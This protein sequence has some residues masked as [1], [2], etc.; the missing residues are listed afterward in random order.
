MNKLIISFLFS[1]C[2]ISAYD[3]SRTS[4]EMDTRGEPVIGQTIQSPTKNYTLTKELGAGAFG[5]VFE[6]ATDLGECF[7]LKWYGAASMSGWFGDHLADHNREFILGQVLD[8]PNIIKS[9]ESFTDEDE[10]PFNYTVLELV[11]G[12][13]LASINRGDLELTDAIAAAKQ[14]ISGIHH[15]FI[16]EYLHLDLHGS[17]IMLSQNHEVKIIDLSSFFSFQEIR[18]HCSEGSSTETYQ[19][20]TSERFKKIAQFAK[21]HPALNVYGSKSKSEISHYAA[22]N[23]DDVVDISIR[24]LLRAKITREQRLNIRAD[25]KKIAWNC[26]A[27]LEE[28]IVI[29]FES[30]LDAID[31]FLDSIALDAIGPAGKP[32]GLIFWG[33]ADAFGQCCNCRDFELIKR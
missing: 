1:F 4:Y 18:E 17:N 12:K 20:T 26:E 32:A 3:S 31:R 7:A 25:L 11:P 28:G 19:K 16:Q 8:H 27:D 9:I 30:Y 5:K 33:E 13:T 6:A 14:F 24:I 23:F 29:D 22:G 10:N 2:F 15:A 21:R